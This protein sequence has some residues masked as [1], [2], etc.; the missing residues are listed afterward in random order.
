[1]EIGHSDGQKGCLTMMRSKRIVGNIY[2]LLG[3]TIVGDVAS[4]KFDKYATELRNM[5]MGHL[6]ECGM[7][8]LHQR[9]L[10]KGCPQLQAG[11]L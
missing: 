9:N 7:M 2:K 6:S 1:M 4:L 5:H 10:L 8:K 3:S 11:F